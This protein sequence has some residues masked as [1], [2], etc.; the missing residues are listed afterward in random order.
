MPKFFKQLEKVAKKVE[1]KVSQN[2]LGLEKRRRIS[3]LVNPDSI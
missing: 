2:V 1:G 3:H